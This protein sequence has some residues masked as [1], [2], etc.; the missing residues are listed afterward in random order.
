[1]RAATCAR[2]LAEGIGGRGQGR[3]LTCV[4]T[5]INEDRNACGKPGNLCAISSCIIEV[6][7]FPIIDPIFLPFP[8]FVALNLFRLRASLNSMKLPGTVC[9]INFASECDLFRI[10][11]L[12]WL[13]Q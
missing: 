1:V 10:Q 7:V 3:S 13:P 8:F 5:L 4:Q 12:L 11:S 2:W 9:L 6:S